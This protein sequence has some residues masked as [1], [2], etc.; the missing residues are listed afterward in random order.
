MRNPSFGGFFFL[1]WIKLINIKFYPIIFLKVIHYE[2]RK[3]E[4]VK[5]VFGFV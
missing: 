5:Y 1:Y 4:N 3:R 2:E